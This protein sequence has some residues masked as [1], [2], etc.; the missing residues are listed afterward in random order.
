MMN[1]IN[2]LKEYYGGK[3]LQPVATSAQIKLAE[4]ELGFSLP[5]SLIQIYTQVANG[6]FGP[7]YGILGVGGGWTDDLGNTAERLYYA[8][9]RTQFKGLLPIC[10]YGCATYALL[11][12]KVENGQILL[13]EANKLKKEPLANS[14][15]EWLEEWLQTEKAKRSVLE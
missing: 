5:D 10:Y 15:R 14:L 4:K 11:D 12:C 9:K 1:I 6:G 3:E 13:L 8:G 2:R 7:G